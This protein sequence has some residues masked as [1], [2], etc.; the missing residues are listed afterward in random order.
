MNSILMKKSPRFLFAYSYWDVIPAVAGVLHGL[1]LIMILLFFK[2]LPFWAN[3]ILGFIYAFSISWNVN[4]ISHNFIHNAY[5]KSFWLNRL[6]SLLESMIMGFSQTMYEYVHRQH[7]IGN[8]DRLNEQGETIDW[9][10]IYGFGKNGEPE[11]PIK[12]ALLSYFRDDPKRIYG[13]IRKH[14]LW[15]ANFAIFEVILS[16]GFII[17]L[18]FINWKLGIY[19]V[20]FYYLGHSLSALN[21][22]YEHYG[23]NPDKPI[24]WAV[25]CYNKLF[26]ILWF[27]NGYHAEHHYRPKQHWTKMHELH[28]KIKD[29]QIKEGVKVINWPHQIGFMQSKTK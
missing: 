17:G 9:I 4:G 16:F 28:V 18:F 14:S 15:L 22:Y 6:F 27:K 26:N 2:Q 21:G 10:S 7:H 20:F 25:S 1:Y 23:A 12:Y 5:F 8:N 3:L 24:A 29:N 11:H 19:Y 13:L